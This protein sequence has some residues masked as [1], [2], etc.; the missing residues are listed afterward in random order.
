MAASAAF[1]F[2]LFTTSCTRHSGLPEPNSKQYTDLVSA[3]YVGL[4]GLQ[5]GEDVRARRRS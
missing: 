5:S 1:A 2:A 4:A 3:F